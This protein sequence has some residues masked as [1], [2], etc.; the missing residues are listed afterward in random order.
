M[1]EG[2]QRLTVKKSFWIYDFLIGSSFRKLEGL[3]KI[4]H[5]SFTN[6]HFFK[7]AC[8]IELNADIE[9][10]NLK[11]GKAFVKY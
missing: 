4:W 8:I 1:T 5:P 2:C 10:G 3:D 6:L 11:L 9:T 7:K